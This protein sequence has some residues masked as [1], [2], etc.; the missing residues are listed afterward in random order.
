MTA[1]LGYS[2]FH[3]ISSSGG[4]IE[5]HQEYRLIGKQRCGIIRCESSLQISR[6][7]EHKVNFRSSEILR[8]N[9][10]FAS[11]NA[12]HLVTS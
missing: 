9:E 12:T 7:I 5:K 3:R 6:Q 11:Q 8:S 4:L 10:V 2:R 1:K